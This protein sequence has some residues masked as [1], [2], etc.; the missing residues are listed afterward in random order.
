MR[1]PGYN[2]FSNVSLYY[3]PPHRIRVWFGC[4]AIRHITRRTHQ[5]QWIM[6]AANAKKI[7]WPWQYIYTAVVI[8]N[9]IRFFI[10]LAWL[11]TTKLACNVQN[12][13]MWTAVNHLPL[14]I[15]SATV[16]SFHSS[17]KSSW[18]A[19]VLVMMLNGYCG[20]GTAHK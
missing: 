15:Y 2:F 14:L 6:N 12:R 18:S 7:C 11:K 13:M 4:L 17:Q 10:S 20:R 3:T 8:S 19:I 5:R 1:Q 9:V 16:Y